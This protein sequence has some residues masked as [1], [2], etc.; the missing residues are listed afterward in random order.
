MKNN[1]IR[2]LTLFTCCA[3]LFVCISNPVRVS[4]ATAT[5][6][7]GLAVNDVASVD[8]LLIPFALAL[9]AAG[10]VFNNTNEL[11][12]AAQDL[13]DRMKPTTIEWAKA[14][15]NKIEAGVQT[16][17]KLTSSVISD[18]NAGI[19]ELWNDGKAIATDLSYLVAPEVLTNLGSLSMT[20]ILLQDISGI[21]TESQTITQ[22]MASLLSNIKTGILAIPQTITASIESLGVSFKAEFDQFKTWFVN[23]NNNLKEEVHQIPNWLSNINTNMKS[24]L[25]QIKGWLS[26]INTNIKNEILGIKTTLGQIKDTAIGKVT[27][28]VDNLGAKLDSVTKSITSL[29]KPDYTISPED[30]EKNKTFF[31]DGF[32]FFG[33]VNSGESESLLGQYGAG[34]FVASS[35]MELFL[36]ITFFYDLILVSLCIGFVGALLGIIANSSRD[37]ISTK[38]KAK[39][40]SKVSGRSTALVVKG[41]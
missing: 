27:T 31:T 11:I 23:I 29:F 22:R 19:T 33:S 20:D 24:E 32:N 35:I 1:F 40:S 25:K 4:A 10:Y 36:S 18:I 2:F 21:L 13:S 30:D 38:S 41:G 34:F 9:L 6:D 8:P 37:G 39:S 15:A 16:V 14:F 17:G 5:I 3:L 26:D 12:D 28:A 7:I